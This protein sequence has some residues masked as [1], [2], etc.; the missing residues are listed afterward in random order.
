MA[1]R[2]SSSSAL[3]I[4]E[5]SHLAVINLFHRVAARPSGKAYKNRAENH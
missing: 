1:R 3:D 4:P 2:V 5:E